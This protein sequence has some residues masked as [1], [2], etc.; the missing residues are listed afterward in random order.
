MLIQILCEEILLSETIKLTKNSN[1]KKY[2]YY[3]YGIAFDARGG[4]SLSNESR[5][6]KNIK[7]IGANVSTLVH[8]DNKKEYILTLFK[9]PTD[10]F[11]DTMLTAEK[12]YSINF[13]K[14]QKKFCLSFH[15]NG[16]NSYVF[17]NC[18]KIYK[19]KAKKFV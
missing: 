17:V 16:V 5:F 6:G 14:Q 11:D 10:G 3:D 15:Y 7:T 18:V 1:P 8:I 2:K 4:F 19:F 13:T 12:E 9:G